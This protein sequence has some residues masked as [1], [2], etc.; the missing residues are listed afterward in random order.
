MSDSPLQQVRSFN[1]TVTESLGVLEE[2][3]LG[4]DR[5][6][7][8]A[9]V[10]WEIGDDGVEVRAL[11]RRLD[12]DSG[13]CSRLLRTLEREGLVEVRADAADGRVRRVTLTDAG[14]TERAELD[15]R[16]DEGAQALL[17]SLPGEEQARLVEAMA[18]VERLILRART[19]VA[20]APA[21]SAEVRYCFGRYY[22]EL[23]RRFESG[24]D[25]GR[26]NPADVADLTPPS[27]FV[28]LARIGRDSVGCG[29]AKLHEDGVAELK[30]MWVSPRTRG[31]GLGRRLL[32]ELERNAAEQGATVARLETNRVLT[33]AVALYRG[34][35]YREV[36]AFNE[37]PYAH[38]WFEKPLE[39]SL[40]SE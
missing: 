33:E 1:R 25:V 3:F 4:R 12:L 28:L 6:I 15:R 34:A 10:L 37:E 26:S 40:T 30:R 20:L 14:R 31:L 27:G 38:H 32:A 35:G 36:P 7:G 11:R 21:G 9:R 5:P 18:Q 17:E 39:T 29:A 2:R 8:A 16:S 13:Y 19:T 22:E 24:F 23:D